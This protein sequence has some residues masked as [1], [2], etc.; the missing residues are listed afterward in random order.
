MKK[1]FLAAMLIA[2]TSI[3]FVAC[4]NGDYN[5]NPDRNKDY[6]NPLN[7]S[8]GVTIPFGRVQAEIDGSLR[9]FDSSTGWT[10][11]VPG[12]AQFQGVKF[13]NTHT[14]EFIGGSLSPWANVTG[15]YPVA[16]SADNDVYYGIMDTTNKITFLLYSGKIVQGGSGAGNIDIKGTE[17]GRLRGTFSGTLFR[18][19]PTLDFSDVKQVTN[20]EFYV[21]KH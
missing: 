5:A 4:N 9:Y 13:D 19:F 2:G 14:A 1:V 21:P 16:D 18:T 8:T 17:S 12:T 6:L 10:D 3:M 11:S 20:G 7:P 15:N